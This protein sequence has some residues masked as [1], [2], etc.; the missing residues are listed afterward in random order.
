MSPCNLKWSVGGLVI[1]EATDFI[2]DIYQQAYQASLTECMPWLLSMHDSQGELK[3][4]CGIRLA[5]EG[6]LFL[7]NYIDQPVEQLM[8]HHFASGLRRERIV[9]I[10]NFAATEGAARVMYAAVCLLLNHYH[11]THIVF[12]GTRKIRNIFARLSLKPV[13]LAEASAER[14]GQM[15]DQWGSYYQ[16]QPQLMAGELAGGQSELSRNSLLFSLFR[17]IPAAPWI[18]TSGVQHVS[19]KA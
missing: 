6:R 19:D 11:F 4:V 15:A 16:Y 1:N 9:E 18:S 17:E 14:L 5:S 10:G 7:E 3:A 12:T 13:L 2:R 8:H